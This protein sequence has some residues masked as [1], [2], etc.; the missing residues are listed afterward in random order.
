M[1]LTIG[2]SIIHGLLIVVTAPLFQGLIKKIKARLQN[3]QG[4]P[5]LQ[6]YY[7]LFKY[8]RKETVISQH[9]SWITRGTPYLTFCTITLSSTLIPTFLDHAPLGFTGDIIVLT[10]L[11]GL[12][13]FFTALAAL[14]SG[15]SFGG[16]GSSR[17]MALS[18]LAEMAL[19]FA[20]FTALL[21]SGTMQIVVHLSNWE[22]FSPAH[23]FAFL[24][25]LIVLIAE[26]GRIPIDNPDT[27]LELTM[28]HEGMLL[29]YSGRYL[30]LMVWAAQ[31]KQFI[32]MSLFIALFFPWGLMTS[33]NLSDIILSLLLFLLKVFLLAVVIAI[34][35]TRYA[36]VRLYLVPRFFIYSM[37]LSLLSILSQSFQ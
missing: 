18:P 7:D 25:M 2:W 21:P 24:A 19:L 31:I 11:L 10:Y 23:L 36:K 17:E 13:R 29:E 5:L 12:S 9:S 16:M 3:R 28:I 34:I 30:G 15:G 6:P 4:P 8:F 1:L 27:H 37:I 22:L 35:E 14:D 20:V 32:M 33:R 26:I